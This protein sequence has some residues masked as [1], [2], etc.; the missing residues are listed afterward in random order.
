MNYQSYYRVL[1][2]GEHSI[3]TLTHVYKVPKKLFKYQQF[4]D[5]SGI[6]NRYWHSNLQGTFHM[7]LAKEFE[8]ILDSVP[9]FD[10]DKIKES[11]FCLL[12]KNTSPDIQEKLYEELEKNITKETFNRIILNYK[13]KIRIGCFT[14][15]SDNYKMWKK[16][17]NGGSGYCIQYRTDNNLLFQ[18]LTLP[19]CYTNQK[20]EM[21]E[22]FSILLILE[23]YK[24]A[25]KRAD[26]QN[27][28]IFI[29]Y[30]KK[31]IQKINFPIFI[32]KPIWN[33]E[34]EYRMY[35]SQ[36]MLNSSK[37]LDKQY[38]LN[39]SNSISAIYLGPCFDNNINSLDIK[40]EVKDICSQKNIHL[41][42]KV[43]IKGKM[44]DQKIL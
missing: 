8:D 5:I 13:E 35:L 12:K 1:F 21:S 36:S 33:F 23:L 20:P 37:Y 24:D 32:K 4:F 18:N 2:S 15:R 34:E 22:V 41:Y 28:L 27:L 25:K 10:E 16:Y 3:N 17:A 26:F 42:Q 19:I 14:T 7:S 43:Y 40:K 29:P 31:I 38:N 39:L 30:Y 11:I 6:E 44:K 9:S